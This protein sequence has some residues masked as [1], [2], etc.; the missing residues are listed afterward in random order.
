VSHWVAMGGSLP[1]A[2]FLLEHNVDF[3]AK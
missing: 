2:L 3:L 1:T